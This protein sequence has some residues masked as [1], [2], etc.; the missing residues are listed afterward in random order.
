MDQS[1]DFRYFRFF[2][3]IT[4]FLFTSHRIR[5]WLH[6]NSGVF[7]D[8]RWNFRM[9]QN[10]DLIWF[11]LRHLFGYFSLSALSIHC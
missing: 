2:I 8:K 1:F 3:V 4:I 6:N 5:Y 11:N 10:M 9:K 7:L